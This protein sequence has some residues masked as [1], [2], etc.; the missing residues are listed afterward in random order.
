MR[1][2]V[3]VG[4]RVGWGAR[5]ARAA[6]TDWRCVLRAK[7]K[8]KLDIRLHSLPFFLPAFFFLLPPPP[9]KTTP[10][11]ARSSTS[12]P[13][14]AA[15]RSAPSSG[16]RCRTS[17][18]CRRRVRRKRGGFFF[19][20]RGRARTAIASLC[21]RPFDPSCL[22]AGVTSHPASGPTRGA[23]GRAESAAAGGPRRPRRPPRLFASQNQCRPL[24]SLPPQAPTRATPTSSWSVSTST[25]TKPPAVS[26]WRA[27]ERG[28]R[29]VGLAFLFLGI[30][31]AAKKPRP[32]PHTLPA[33]PAVCAPRDGVLL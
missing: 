12:R 10:P 24:P 23:A 28:G 31:Q 22:G 32:A 29:R 7:K 19:W 5:H 16:R 33:S 4:V 6:K 26:G 3:C 25:S 8:K 2:L 9:T 14:S 1:G 17:T 30:G 18:A 11:C 21:R 27:R 15:T 13:A 20:E